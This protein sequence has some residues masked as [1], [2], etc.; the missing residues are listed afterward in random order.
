MHQKELAMKLPR[1]LRVLVLVVLLFASAAFGQRTYRDSEG[2]HVR[3]P[4]HVAGRHVPAGASARCRDGSYTALATIIVA[5]V[6]IT[7]ELLYGLINN[8]FFAANA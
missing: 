6:R 5:P 8:L 4:V 2:R 7:A 3:R 1:I